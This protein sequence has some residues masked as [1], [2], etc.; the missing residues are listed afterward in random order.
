MVRIESMEHSMNDCRIVES[1]KERQTPGALLRAETSPTKSGG[2]TGVKA[3][4]EG[5]R[6]SES[7][8]AAAR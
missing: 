5:R 6:V 3:P 1:C 4:N 2:K 8:Y 7:E